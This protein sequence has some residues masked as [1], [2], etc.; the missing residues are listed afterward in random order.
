MWQNLNPEDVIIGKNAIENLTEGMYKNPLII[1]REYIQNAADG[2]DEAKS[3]GIYKPGEKPE[4]DIDVDPEKRFIRI[5]DN[6][7]GVKNADWHSLI[8]I[9]DSEKDREVNKGFRGIGRL[10]GLA[11]CT[12]LRFITS[13]IGESVKTIIEWNAKQLMQLSPRRSF[14]LTC[15]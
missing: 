3:A 11:Y 6:G 13:H 14:L 5:S 7:I 1:Y 2:I 15:H 8:N 12:T 4:I 10:G 9:A